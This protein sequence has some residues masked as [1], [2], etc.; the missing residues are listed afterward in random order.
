MRRIAAV[1]VAGL[2]LVGAALASTTAREPSRMVVQL[3]DLPAG[4]TATSRRERPNATV[5]RETGV[6]LTTLRGWGRVDGFEVA[7]DRPVDPAAPPRGAAMVTSTVS[8]YGTAKGL[9]LAYAAS[10]ERIAR[11]GK[12]R[13]VPLALTGKLGDAARL[14]R[15]RF[16]QDGVPVVLFTLVWRSAGALSHVAIAGVVGRL[17]AGDALAIARAQQAHVLAAAK[18]AGPALVA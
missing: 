9:R 5:A 18:P 14:W 15:T 2:A 3:G 12:P 4:F 17:T 10:I 8:T 13:H 16:S 6:P 11:A 7:F 1:C